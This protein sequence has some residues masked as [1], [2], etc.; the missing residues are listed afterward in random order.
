MFRLYLSLFVREERMTS[1]RVHSKPIGESGPVQVTHNAG[2][3][4]IEW[5][6]IEYPPEKKDQEQAVAS[7]FIETLNASE[8]PKWA[9]NAL[10]EDDFDFEMSRGDEKRYLELQEVI[11]PG[12]KRGPPYAKGEQTIE[13]AKFAKTIVSAIN[14][15]AIKYPPALEQPLDLLIYPTHWRFVPNP[16]VLQLVCDSL[17][18]SS[19]PFSN[20]YFF[21]RL[22]ENESQRVNLFPSKELLAGFNREEAEAT[23]YV[24]FDPGSG[25]AFKDGDRVGVRFALTP[26]VTKKLIEPKSST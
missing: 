24:N 25:E 14:S 6:K 20:I 16:S 21:N 7:S 11:I 23:A 15:K 4:T 19:H 17:H 2:Q 9:L 8:D 10:A 18:K 26:T 12:K 5:Q 1:K 13:P 22:N 3:T